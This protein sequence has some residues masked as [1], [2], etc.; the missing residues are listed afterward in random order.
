MVFLEKI[1]DGTV[2]QTEERKQRPHLQAMKTH[3][4]HKFVCNM[5][6]IEILV[7]QS[8]VYIYIYIYIYIPK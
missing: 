8:C 4:K 3:Y 7:M 1:E 6:F 5:Q 2:T